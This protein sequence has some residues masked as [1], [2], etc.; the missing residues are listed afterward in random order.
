MDELWLSGEYFTA[1]ITKN[2]KSKKRAVQRYSPVLII[3]L[4]RMKSL[5]L[6]LPPNIHVHPVL[7]VEE[8][9]RVFSQPEDIFQETLS[10][11]PPVIYHD[12]NTLIY[13]VKILAYRKRG[14]SNQYLA[15]KKAPHCMKLSGSPLVTFWKMTKQSRRH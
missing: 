7:H 2:Q 4:V 5:Q 9:A 6:E 3:E 14:N 11:P 15:A 12:L 1:S 13:V 10:Q 8:T